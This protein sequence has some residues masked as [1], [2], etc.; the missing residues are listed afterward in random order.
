MHSVTASCMHMHGVPIKFTNYYQPFIQLVTQQTNS[1]D[2][3]TCKYA[4]QRWWAFLHVLQ[5]SSW[6]VLSSLA[7]LWRRL[8]AATV[9]TGSGNLILLQLPSFGERRA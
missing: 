9:A 1:S 4:A 7:L 8:V 5:V 2:G 6:L 3:R